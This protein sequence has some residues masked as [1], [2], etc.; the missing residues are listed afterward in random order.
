MAGAHNGT[1]A[2]EEQKGKEIKKVEPD[3]QRQP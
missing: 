1:K 3:K 2:K